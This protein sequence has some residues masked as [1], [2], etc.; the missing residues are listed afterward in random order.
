MQQRLELPDFREMDPEVAFR[1]RIE[2]QRY[3]AAIK[4]IVTKLEILDEE[5]SLRH[6]Y[7]PIHHI[8]SRLKPLGSIEEK[9]ARLGKP[10]SP[11]SMV[12]NL[13]DVAGVRVICK[14]L[15]DAER[16]AQTL[17]MQDDV[18]LLLRKD[19]INNPKSNGYR[20]LHMVVSTP[21]FLTEGKRETKVEI[22]IRTIAMD[23]WASLEHH[24]HYK[25][26][27]E[28]NPEL[29]ERLRRSAETI[30]QVDME[31]QELYELILGSGAAGNG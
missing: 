18:T 5:F 6:A 30:H 3:S 10:F 19:Y 31:M 14:Y 1:F 7:N 24:L 28:L 4:G 26:D 11:D 21:I 27:A 23:M 9:L 17:T 25:S 20:S 13:H 2:F 15:D 16:I 22:Q 8:E 12:A 29:I